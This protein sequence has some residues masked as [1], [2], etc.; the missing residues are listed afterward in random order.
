MSTIIPK[1][2]FFSLLHTKNMEPIQ[3]SFPDKET[4]R[5]L[6]EELVQQAHKNIAPPPKLAEI[7]ALA[8]QAAANERVMA[9]DLMFSCMNDTSADIARKTCAEI[10]TKLRSCRV[11]CTIRVL[12]PGM[13]PFWSAFV[14]DRYKEYNCREEKF[15]YR[16]CFIVLDVIL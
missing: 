11:S 16:S 10:D 8:E 4:A 7:Q 6:Q 13:M 3:T 14:L 2:T 9:L 1:I 5:V 12:V 15:N